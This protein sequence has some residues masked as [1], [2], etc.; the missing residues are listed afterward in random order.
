VEYWGLSVSLQ[1][2]GADHG[3]TRYC[4]FTEANALKPNS[5]VYQCSTDPEIFCKDKYFAW[6]PDLPY[7]KELYIWMNEFFVV[8]NTINA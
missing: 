4:C 3:Y 7:K 1:V 8:E 6:A 5:Y 2:T